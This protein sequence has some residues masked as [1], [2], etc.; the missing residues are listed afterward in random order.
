MGLSDDIKRNA[1][2]IA[3]NGERLYE[4]ALDGEYQAYVLDH[5]L[6]TINAD[7]PLSFNEW[8]AVEKHIVD[9]ENCD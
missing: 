7:Y 5:I 4:L 3:V 2:E 1:S 9:C 8:L 6:K